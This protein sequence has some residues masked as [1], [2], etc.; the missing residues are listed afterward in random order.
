MNTPRAEFT[1]RLGRSF[2]RSSYLILLVLLILVQHASGQAVSFGTADSYPA[3]KGPR[4]LASGDLNGDGKLDLAVTNLNGD[5]VSILLNKG[6]GTF[7]AAVNYPVGTSP[8]L[9][10]AG[11]FNR[12][13]AIDLAVVNNGSD[14][15]SI[16]LGKGD[17]T[18]RDA[19]N[20]AAGKAPL[21]LIAGDFNH[22]DR[23]DLAVTSGGTV[24]VLLGNGDGVFQSA[25][26]YT[27]GV[28]SQYISTG[29]FNSD[30][31]PDLVTANVSSNNLSVL[32]N[33]GDGTFQPAINS[34]SGSGPASVGVGDYNRDGKPDVAVGTLYDPAAQIQL[35]NGDG[36]FGPPSTIHLG[37]TPTDIKA[38]DFNGDGKLDL[39][40]AGV[41][42]GSNVEIL[43]GG[44]DGT[45]KSAGSLMNSVG[46]VAVIVADFNGDTRPDIAAALNGQVSVVLINATPGK[47][48]NTQYFVHQHYLDFLDREPDDRGF[49]YWT[50]Q[51]DRCSTDPDCVR[52]RRI[53]ISGAF[54]VEMEFQQSGYFVYR[55]YRAAFG[56][57]PSY[58]E[59]TS[60][61][62]KVVGGTELEAS[63]T[64][65]ASGFTQRD[66]FK[67][68]YPDSL[69]NEAFVNKLF[70][71]AGLMPF[72]S[73]RAAAIASLSQGADRASVLQGL[74]DNQT[75]KQREYNP[76]FVQMQYFGYLRRDEDI[77]GYDFWLKVM[78]EQP[79]N[80]PRMVC[81]FITSAEYQLRF[82]SNVTRTNQECGP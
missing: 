81:A 38:G 32:L 71:A 63:K 24:R 67:Q 61:R 76:A 41:F 42:Q 23:K 6:D 69:S 75:F 57:R 62:H 45:F 36:T 55:L 74:I 16:L 44:G 52:E 26:S 13:D 59:F 50:N 5:D 78:N 43:L 46:A 34:G 35:G 51:I 70:D 79:N 48:D 12:D 66:A 80:Y 4:G 82:S 10:T 18:F 3:G 60:D 1:Q 17:G 9:I 77:K 65:L 72:A 30:G 15:L 25:V 2:A 39:V 27:V 28:A 40:S 29:D 49:D 22:D 7:K 68:A 53:G 56:R 37:N 11:D 33:K 21:S 54:F 8:M 14:N 64:A 20:Y 47:P 73:E 19:V 31:K 58:A